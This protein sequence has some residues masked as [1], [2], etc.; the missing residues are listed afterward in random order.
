MKGF[1]PVRPTRAYEAVAEQIEKA[2]LSGRF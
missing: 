1:E 2:I